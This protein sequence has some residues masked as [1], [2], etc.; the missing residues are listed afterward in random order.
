M[1]KLSSLVFVLAVLIAVTFCGASPTTKTKR[2]LV[3]LENLQLR[4]SHSIFFNFLEE[5]Y[6]LDYHEA[7]DP[8]LTLSKYGE[9]LYDILVIFA[10]NTDE[11]GKIDVDDVLNFIDDGNSVLVAGGTEVSETIRE[12]ASECG[13]EF[14]ED[15]SYVIDHFNFDRS[16]FDGDHTLLVADNWLKTA[17]IITGNPNAPLLWRGIGHTLEKE[18]RLIIPLLR[19]SSTAYSSSEKNDFS[20]S[21]KGKELVLVSALQARNNA[22]VTFSG[23]L[24]FFSDRF[25][26]STVQKYATDGKAQVFDKSGNE[27]F[28]RNLVR[29]TFGFQGVLRSG[30]MHHH[31]VGEKQQQILYTI[32]EDIEY[33]VDIEEWD[34]K[35]WKPYNSSDVQ[36]EFVMLHPYVRTGLQRVSPKT[37]TFKTV[38]KI[39]DVYG[40]YTFRL[41]Y[42]RLGYTSLSEID[43]V[44]IRPLRHDQ[45]ERFIVSAFPYYISSLSMIAGLIVFGF[46]FLYH[47]DDAAPAD[48]R[49]SS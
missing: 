26:Q 23:S 42:K 46:V 9:Y 39:P 27:E 21:G 33:T 34:G 44:T 12:I 4:N 1:M 28:V 19:A 32:K 38:F 13:V 45:Y 40:I 15:G 20:S 5:L 49:V 31:R 6:S 29:W 25:L 2:G 43:R 48:K 14:E 10:P 35:Q 16:D 17:P 37:S 11:F 30:N 22:R 36:L 47:K 3:L 8:K 7:S 41:D 24:D 18:N